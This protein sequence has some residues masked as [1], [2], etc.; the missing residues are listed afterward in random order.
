M[1]E[2]ELSKFNE[3]V[4]KSPIGGELSLDRVSGDALVEQKKFKE[5]FV[6]ESSL[7]TG[8]IPQVAWKVANQVI[9]KHKSLNKHR[10]DYL[11]RQLI[12]LTFQNLQMVLHLQWFEMHQAIWLNMPGL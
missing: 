1:A 4:T 10:M 3:F 5:I 12:L 11:Q 7:M 8:N 9:S 6:S 2:N